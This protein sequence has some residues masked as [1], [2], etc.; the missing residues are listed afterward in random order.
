MIMMAL[1][2]VTNCCY[3]SNNSWQVVDYA[4]SG[5]RW[6]ILDPGWHLE[7]TS[8]R[9]LSQVSNGQAQVCVL[10]AWHPAQICIRCS[11]GH[12]MVIRQRVVLPRI[13]DVAAEWKELRQTDEPIEV[14]RKH[15]MVK[16]EGT[17]RHDLFC[18]RG[19]WTGQWATPMVAISGPL[20]SVGAGSR[21]GQAIFLFAVLIL[22][23]RILCYLS[24][25]VSVVM[26]RL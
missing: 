7:N 20:G 26:V 24:N 4:G 18:G 2:T 1:D 17:T 16:A 25:T 12:C 5:W 6:R 11:S 23:K 14:A 3:C 21:M 9:R 10:P 19:V 13:S 8:C 22:L 15:V